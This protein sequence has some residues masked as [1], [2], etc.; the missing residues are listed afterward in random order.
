[1]TAK[2]ENLHQSLSLPKQKKLIHLCANEL[3]LFIRGSGILWKWL[4][5]ELSHHFSQCDSSPSHQRSW[6]KSSDWLE[7]HYHCESEGEWSI[8]IIWRIRILRNRYERTVK[9]FSPSPVL[10]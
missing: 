5:L 4:L 7:S 6:R 9:F 10:L 2:K 8:F 1:M 3:G